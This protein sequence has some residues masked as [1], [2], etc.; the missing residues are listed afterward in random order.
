MREED[1]QAPLMTV[2]QTEEPY[3]DSGTG[4]LI[5]ATED[6]AASLGLN[7]VMSTTRT[8]SQPRRVQKRKM[9]SH[10][11]CGKQAQ[12]PSDFCR[13]HGGGRRCNYEGCGR[14]AIN[15]SLF[16]RGHGGGNRCT[17]EY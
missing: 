8:E 14:T 7:D 17:Y 12:W 5:E 11:G 3:T 6:R 16:C 9:C 1:D 10:E 4:D 13:Q 15:P 2:L